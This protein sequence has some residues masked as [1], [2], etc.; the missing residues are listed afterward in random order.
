MSRD[1]FNGY[2][3]WGIMDSLVYISFIEPKTQQEAVE[4]VYNKSYDEINMRPFREARKRLIRSGELK[5]DGSMRNAT[6]TSSMQPFIEDVEKTYTEKLGREMSSKN[7]ERLFKIVDSDWFRQFFREE[8]IQKMYWL[9]RNDSERLDYVGAGSYSMMVIGQV[10]RDLWA[11]GVPRRLDTSIKLDVLDDYQSLDD[12]VEEYGRS[13]FLESLETLPEGSEIDKKE[14]HEMV[15]DGH[16]MDRPW[17]EDYLDELFES[18]LFYKLP[19]IPGDVLSSIPGRQ[20]SYYA[21]NDCELPEYLLSNYVLNS[22]AFENVPEEFREEFRNNLEIQLVNE[23]DFKPL[24]SVPSSYDMSSQ[25]VK[26][27]SQE[28]KQKYYK[29]NLST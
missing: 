9:G 1:N 22:L 25:E 16:N 4:L 8:L 26:N 13:F 29:I 15:K 14:A 11:F 23:N 5:S 7:A 24:E 6:F 18:N 19:K 10:V 12:Y 3:G 17:R 21:V 2:N 20:H 28:F 27:I